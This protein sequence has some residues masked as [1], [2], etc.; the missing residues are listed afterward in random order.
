MIVKPIHLPPDR[1]ISEAL[2]LMSRFH[3]SGIPVTQDGKL[4][5]IL[6]NR[7]LKYEEDLTQKIG[8]VMTKD[9][10]VTAYPGITLDE[11]K[12]ILHQ[13]NKVR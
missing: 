2:E 5:G 3:I 1:L 13:K 6:T 12:K 4:V 8:D 9:N 11:A 7:D 10:L